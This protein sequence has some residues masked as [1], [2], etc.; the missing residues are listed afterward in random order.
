LAPV[1]SPGDLL[2]PGL[3]QVATPVESYG[4]PVPPI[5]IFGI[6]P[7]PA[8][9]GGAI[10]ALTSGGGPVAEILGTLAALAASEYLAEK[11]EQR[12]ASVGPA[13]G[14]ARAAFGPMLARAA[15]RRPTGERPDKSFEETVKRLDAR[16]APDAGSEARTT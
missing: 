9:P 4:M 8:G 6:G 13:A 14:P 2:I 3:T 11:P 7:R 16:L 10:E 5:R 1:E 15:G 12:P